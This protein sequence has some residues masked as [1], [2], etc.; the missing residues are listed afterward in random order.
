MAKKK[1]GGKKKRAS[2]RAKNLDVSSGSARR[3]KGGMSKY[4]K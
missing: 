3:V 2:K 1:A 4:I